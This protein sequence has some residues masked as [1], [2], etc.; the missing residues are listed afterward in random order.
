MGKK[1]VA[2]TAC[3]ARFGTRRSILASRTTEIGAR[4]IKNQDFEKKNPDFHIPYHFFFI[5]YQSEKNQALT[6][7]RYD[8]GK[9]TALAV[10]SSTFKPL[11]P[12]SFSSS[13]RRR[14]LE[15]SRRPFSR[16]P[17]RR[18]HHL[19]PLHAATLAAPTKAR[20]M[21]CRPQAAA[22]GP[23]ARG[24]SPRTRRT[25]SASCMTTSRMPPAGTATQMNFTVYTRRYS[26]CRASVVR[27]HSRG[28]YTPF[29]IFT[30]YV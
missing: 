22:R 19:R 5:P 12:T 8:T 30:T 11:G 1:G 7:Y 29:F 17:T 14:A 10:G 21:R 25:P 4:G 18:L 20:A 15:A 16:G 28:P 2:R 6:K 13:S 27:A 3:R 23:R 26:T 24:A 9:V